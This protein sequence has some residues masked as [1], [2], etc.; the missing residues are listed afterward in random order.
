[1]PDQNQNPT[2]APTSQNQGQP[3]QGKKSNVGLIIVIVILVIL[4]LFGVGGY[5]A[6][7][8]AKNKVNNV[9]NSA[10]TTGSTTSS[11]TTSSGDSAQNTANSVADTYNSA[12]DTTPTTGLGVEVNGEIKT[13]LAEVF[14]GAKLSEWMDLGSGTVLT[15]TL[16]RQITT[17][18]YA[19][20]ETAFINKGYVKSVNYTT[21]Q[22]FSVYF[23]KNGKDILLGGTVGE[24]KVSATI[25][26]SS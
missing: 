13:T 21:D 6:Y 24:Q 3:V 26:Q 18:D 8:Y 25:S 16:K 12:K 11:G 10:S 22:D 1:M 5:L 15:Y 17:S 4:I 20:V 9:L 7:R 2:P 14:G 19:K 23:S